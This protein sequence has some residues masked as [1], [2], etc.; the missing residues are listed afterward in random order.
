MLSD[1]ILGR[2]GFSDNLK[3]TG[4]MAARP[5]YPYLLVVYSSAWRFVFNSTLTQEVT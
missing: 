5:E 1:K 2:K 3:E 4:T